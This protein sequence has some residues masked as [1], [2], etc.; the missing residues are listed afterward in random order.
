MA[1]VPPLLADIYDFFDDTYLRLILAIINNLPGRPGN[2]TADRLRVWLV[3]LIGIKCYANTKLSRGFQVYKL[4]NVE[5]GKNCSLGS[6]FQLWNFN[7]VSMGDN[8][9]LS[10]NVTI[11]CGTHEVSLERRD[12]AG[13]VCI[14]DNV[15]IGANVLIVGPASIGSNTVIGANSF[16]S[17]DIPSSW[18]YAGSPAKPIRE[19]PW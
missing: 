9:L 5:I 3:H 2:A 18:I 1:K 11:I 16:V 12:I 8:L 7:K 17:G 10:H 19:L 4:G 6:N 13:S 14:G 15:W